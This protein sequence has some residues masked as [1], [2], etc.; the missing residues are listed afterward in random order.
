MF[1]NLNTKIKNYKSYLS[2]KNLTL[3]NNKILEFLNLDKITGTSRINRIAKGAGVH[4][5]E[6]RSLLKQY[7]LLNDM[8]QGGMENLDMS[9]GMSQKQMQKLAKKFMKGKKFRL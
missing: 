2:F 1:F 6:I 9:Q 4:N 5:S 7:D 8:I 3:F